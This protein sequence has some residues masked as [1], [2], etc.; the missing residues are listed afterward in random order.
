MLCNILKHAET[1]H[2]T[3]IWHED[4]S[5]ITTNDFSD[6]FIDTF[7]V[8]SLGEIFVWSCEFSLEDSKFSGALKYIGPME[9]ASK[10]AYVFKLS[11]NENKQTVKLKNVV[12][13]ETESFAEV[14]LSMDSCVTLEYSTMIRRY[15]NGTRLSYQ[16]CVKS[17]S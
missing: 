2:G 17:C 9:N 5:R 3:N 8:S 16:L 12:L 4:S 6:S 10:F 7:L 11:K 14:F 15:M 13:K 1:A